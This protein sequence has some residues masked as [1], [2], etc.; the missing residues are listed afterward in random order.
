MALEFAPHH[1]ADRDH[2]GRLGAR[3]AGHEVNRDHHDLQQPAAQM[4]DQSHSE[5]HQANADTAFFH[6]QP[7]PD[8]EWERE[9]D[10]VAGAV[11]GVLSSRDQ[12]CGIGDLKK[13]QR[14]E[15]HREG[16]RQAEQ[17]GDK[18]QRQHDRE[19][20]RIVGVRNRKHAN[21]GNGRDQC[22]D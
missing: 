17:D 10:E 21:S 20:G 22:D 3:D 9:E 11:H 7:G 19:R 15:Q 1:R 5:A 6:D 4:A 13:K 14:P 2:I 12:W 8:E 16:D 18:E